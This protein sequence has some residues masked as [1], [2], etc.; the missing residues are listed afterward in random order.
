M[1]LLYICFLFLEFYYYIG[2]AMDILIGGL[3]LAVIVLFLTYFLHSNKDRD[4]SIPYAKYGSYP[5]IGHLFSFMN[6][7]TKLLLECTQRYGQ[8]FRIKVLNEHYTMISS[9]ADWMTVVRNQSFQ[10][11]GIDFGIKIFGLSSSFLSKYQSFKAI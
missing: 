1:F 6:N 9:H 4:P 11:A 5:I 8:C 3:I 7:R 2:V 10:F